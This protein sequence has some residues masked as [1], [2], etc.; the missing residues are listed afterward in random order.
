MQKLKKIS[1]FRLSS[2]LR[3]Q[4]DPKLALRLFLNP[5]PNDPN[6]KPKPFRYSLLSYDLIISKLGRAKMF[7]EMENIV[8]KL[9]NDTRIIPEEIIFCNIITFYGRARLP[10]KAL[11]VF[12]EIP[13]YRCQRT[14]KSVNTLL[15]SLLMCRKFDKMTEFLSGIEKYG[16]PVACTYNILINACCMRSDLERARELFDEMRR[17]GVEPNVVT[18]GTLIN[19]LCANSELGMAFSLRRRME[20]D[21][22][23]RPNAH[24]YVALIKALCK[25]NHLN[26]AIELKNEMLRKKVELD[27]AVYSTLISAFFKFGRKVEVSG[28]LEEMKQNGCKPNTVTYNAMIFG[29]CQEKEFDKAFEALSEMEKEGC[30][31]DVISY[32]VIISRLCRVRKVREANDL[33]EDM[34]RLKCVPDVVTYRTLFEGF[35]DVK[36]FKEAASL[37]DEM[38]FMGY[39]PHS[40]SVSKYVT[41]LVQGK[42]AELWTFLFSLVKRNSIDGYMW[43]LVTSL[44]CKNNHSDAHE[45][46]NRLINTHSFSAD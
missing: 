16:S 14:I 34:P 18:F 29:F 43:R 6:P 7:S 28:L 41:E 24:I 17:R 40:S 21:F 44:V 13:S 3:L 11:Q 15:N 27:P 33:F 26:E 20:R 23:I 8:E 22:K 2:L 35:C 10:H 1:P 39:A 37:L 25:V 42:N 46:F 36:Q 19:G 9:K 31:P 30:K 5:N 32:N 12:D 45:L 38:I 4:K